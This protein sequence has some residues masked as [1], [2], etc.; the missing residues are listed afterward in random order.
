MNPPRR[1][2][3]FSIKSML[4]VVALVGCWLAYYLNWINQRHKFLMT[5]LHFAANDYWTVERENKPLPW[6]LRLFGER[7]ISKLFVLRGMTRAE[8]GVVRA[9]FPE[10]DVQVSFIR[11]LPE[12]PAAARAA[13]Q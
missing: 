4:V 7:G 1:R 2:L 3:R 9:L 8:V 11:V 13:D 12:E 10:A 6:Q 5:E